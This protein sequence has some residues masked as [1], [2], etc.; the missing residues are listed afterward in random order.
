MPRLEAS[1]IKL[2]ALDE[3]HVLNPRVRTR[4]LLTASTTTASQTRNIGPP[5]AGGLQRQWVSC[6]E[7]S[8][9]LHLRTSL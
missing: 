5:P 9:P 4:V 3:I 7:V 6:Q 2:I 8:R 1:D